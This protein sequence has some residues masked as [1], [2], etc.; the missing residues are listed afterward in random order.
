MTLLTKLPST[1]ALFGEIAVTY[2]V[3][4]RGRASRLVVKMVAR[5]PRGLV[6][7]LQ[8]LL[9]PWGDLVMMRKQLLTLKELAEAQARVAPKRA[10]AMTDAGTGSLA[11]PSG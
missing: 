4:P 6:G 8:R 2:L 9:L 5:Y 7:W 3:L 11:V 1:I 10:R